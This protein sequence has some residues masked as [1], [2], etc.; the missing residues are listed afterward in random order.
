MGLV[1]TTHASKHVIPLPCSTRESPADRRVSRRAAPMHLQRRCTRIDRCF[2]PRFARPVMHHT[3]S[4]PAPT[5]T[6]MSRSKSVVAPSRTAAGRHWTSLDVI[7]PKS[8]REIA[9]GPMDHGA[10]RPIRP[11]RP[12]RRPVRGVG[13]ADPAGALMLRRAPDAHP[14]SGTR[15]REGRCHGRHEQARGR[16]SGAATQR[17]ATPIH[18]H[19]GRLRRHGGRRRHAGSR[20]EAAGLSAGRRRGDQQRQ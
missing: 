17:I 12:A 14:P 6:R 7:G 11:F 1:P 16:P 20:G 4:A 3:L 9:V 13:N 19:R 18:G 2:A 10:I 15:T 8:G 5:M